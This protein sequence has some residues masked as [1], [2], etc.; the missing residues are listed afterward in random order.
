MAERQDATVRI[1]A[2]PQQKLTGLPK[3]KD[4]ELTMVPRQVIQF[5]GISPEENHPKMTVTVD[6]TGRS[7]L[8][9]TPTNCMSGNEACFDSP[10]MHEL[11][12]PQVQNTLSRVKVTGLS[13][14]WELR[15]PRTI[16]DP[17]HPLKILMAESPRNPIM[18][19]F[20]GN[21]GSVPVGSVPED[22]DDFF[23]AMPDNT[24]ALEGSSLREGA[25]DVSKLS[26][27]QKTM[28]RSLIKEVVAAGGALADEKDL[29]SDFGFGG[30]FYLKIQNG[31]TY[32]I[33]KGYSGVR[34][35]FRGTRYS[36][37]KGYARFSI[38]TIAQGPLQAAKAGLPKATKGTVVGFLFM[39]GVNTWTWLAEDEESRFVSDLLIDIGSDAVKA[40]LGG[41]AAAALIGLG[42]LFMP[43][44]VPVFFVIAGTITL[45]IAIGLGLDFLD[46]KIGVTDSVKKLG[47]KAETGMKDLWGEFILEPIGEFLQRCEWEIRRGYGVP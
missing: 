22:L 28:L 3:D 29:L 18:A 6:A 20:P 7:K 8:H 10:G 23:I 35:I 12:I 34:S 11:W 43:V 45:G 14:A 46:E 15:I 1:Q 27:L 25:H 30:K 47:R 5:Q 41:V 44:T 17:T 9:Y 39:G 4:I 42:V 37:E 33:F 16:F 38:L 32:V 13:Q 36:L 24:R 26:D 31:K 40:V 21:T 19:P 2:F